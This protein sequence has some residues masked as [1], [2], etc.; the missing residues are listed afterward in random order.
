MLI[1]VDGAVTIIAGR[2]DFRSAFRSS[3]KRVRCAAHK[4]LIAEMEKRGYYSNGVPRQ[5]LPELTKFDPENPMFR[6][7]DTLKNMETAMGA[8]SKAIVD[9]SK[10]R[11]PHKF[12]GNP[13]TGQNIPLEHLMAAT[14]LWPMDEVL[15]LVPF[16]KE[17]TDTSE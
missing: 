2:E 10:P 8:F 13:E 9:L 5:K 14:D 6:W 7:E 1:K 3:N 12:W 16:P 11:E 17:M 4:N 15:Q